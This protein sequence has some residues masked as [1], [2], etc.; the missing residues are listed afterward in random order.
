MTDMDAGNTKSR[1]GLAFKEASNNYTNSYYNLRLV[2]G[3]DLHRF[4]GK[5]LK[6]EMGGR[7]T[8]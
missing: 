8:R 4:Q 5:L 2:L 1:T 6:V 7:T 3:G